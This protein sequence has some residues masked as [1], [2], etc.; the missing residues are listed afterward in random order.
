MFFVPGDYITLYMGNCFINIGDY[1]TQYS[2]CNYKGS[3]NQTM[4]LIVQTM[5]DNHQT[6]PQ[7]QNNHRDIFG[8]Q[9]VNWLQKPTLRG[10]KLQELHPDRFTVDGID[11]LPKMA[12]EIWEHE[13]SILEQSD[14]RYGDQNKWSIY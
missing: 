10:D 1:T 14:Q 8:D 7:S 12:L 9:E 6:I 3:R 2:G 13:H 4:N 5:Q 11:G